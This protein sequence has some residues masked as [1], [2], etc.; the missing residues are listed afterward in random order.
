VRTWEWLVVLARF[1]LAQWTYHVG[2]W[3]HEVNA[4]GKHLQQSVD[5]VR[6]N[7]LLQVLPTVLQVGT[8]HDSIAPFL[9]FAADESLFLV[10]CDISTRKQLL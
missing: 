1:I 5:I 7:R 4:L 8:G 3:L 6:Q 2:Q 10:P 9:V